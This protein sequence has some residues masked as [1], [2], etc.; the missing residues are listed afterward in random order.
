MSTPQFRR[1]IDALCRKWRIPESREY[2]CEYYWPPFSRLDEAGQQAFWQVLG[3]PEEHGTEA[4]Y[5]VC[6][7]RRSARRP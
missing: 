2:V 1:V 3:M 4:I 7:Q 5:G 6:D